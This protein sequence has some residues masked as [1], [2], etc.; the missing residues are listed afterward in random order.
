MAGLDGVVAEAS[1]SVDVFDHLSGFWSFERRVSG[2]AEMVGEATFTRQT[3]D[4]LQYAEAGTMVLASGDRLAFSRR[5]IY[6][7]SAAGFEIHFDETP[8]RLFQ[9]V[10]LDTT[11]NLITGCGMHLCGQDVYNSIYVFGAMDVFKTVHDVS[12]PK[13]LWSI[14]TLYF[15]QTNHGI[16]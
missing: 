2:Q 16:A 12:G 3:S 10:K 5:Y 14:E 8:L 4:L 13:K 1:L 9:S 15:R 7:R 6:R 11:K